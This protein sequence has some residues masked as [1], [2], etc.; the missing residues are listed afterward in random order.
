MSTEKDKAPK[1][2]SKKAAKPKQAA[3]KKD[4]LAELQKQC[5]EYLGGWQ[6]A[7][8]DYDNLQ[9]QTAAKI[10]D[11]IKHATEEFLQELL[12]MVDYFNYA[13]KGV[14]EEDR[15]SEWLKGM[16]HIQTNFLRI[17]EAHGVRQIP[18]VGEPFDPELHEA[19]EEITGGESGVIAEE[20][21]AGFRL[22]EKVIRIA[23]VKIYK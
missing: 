4:E 18:T 7:R 19:V 2:K 14:P 17:L 16:E 11:T 15:D 1:G 8:A 20:V 6:R 3:K 23:K 5:A 9:R 13:F 21:A 12:P 10:S 22:N